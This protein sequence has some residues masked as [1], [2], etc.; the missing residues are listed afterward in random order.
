MQPGYIQDFEENNLG[1]TAGGTG[2]AWAWGS[3]TSGPGGAY[4]GDKLIATNLEGTY[5]A[6]SNA[7]LLAPPIDLTD[8][9]EGGLLTFKHWYDLERNIDWGKVYIA[10]EENDFA[11]QEVLS[12]TGTSGGWVTQ[13]V[14]LRAYAGQQVFVQFNLTSDASVQKA[15]WYIDDFEIQAPDDIA[16]G[17]PSGL[18]VSADIL[19]N[20]TLNWTG[21]DAEDL[22]SYTVYRSTASGTGYEAIGNTAATTYTD[23]TTVTGSTYYY[24]VAAVDYSGNESEKS[25]EVSID[26]VVPEDIYTD[27]FD[28]SSDNGW[29]HSGVKDEWERGVPVSGPGHAFSVPNAWAT[30]LDNTYESGSNYFLVSWLWI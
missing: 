26:I 25:S 12:F 9:P 17:A 18:A 29:T 13:Y 20:A 5:G 21:P 11:F 30:D 10:A 24:T 8:S 23:T 15:G 6:N 14:D 28:G 22:K 1:F 3:P 16:P 27:H 2:S 4:S 19:G 7:Y